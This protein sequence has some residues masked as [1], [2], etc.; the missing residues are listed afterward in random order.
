[1]L[2]RMAVAV[3]W[4]RAG[5]ERRVRD[6]LLDLLGLDEPV[7]TRGDGVDPL[8]A[9]SDGDARDAVPVRLLLQP[10]GVRED[11]ARLRGERGQIEIAERIAD[12]EEPP[13]ADLLENRAGP[14]MRRKDDRLTEAVEAVDDPAQAV[15]LDVGLAVDGHEHVV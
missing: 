9:R 8:R 15:R 13:S 14:W 7:C 3:E 5:W 10:A 4:R 1:L 2:A 12:L 6:G 11:H